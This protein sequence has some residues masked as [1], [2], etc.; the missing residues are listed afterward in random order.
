MHG[1]LCGPLLPDVDTE[2]FVF[3]S[4]AFGYLHQAAAPNA[5]ERA[6]TVALAGDCNLRA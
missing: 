6:R 4:G 3:R 1:C 5:T 2:S